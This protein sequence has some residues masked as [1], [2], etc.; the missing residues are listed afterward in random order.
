MSTTL[1]WGALPSDL[2]SHFGTS[3]AG[4]NIYFANKDAD[5][6]AVL[7]LTKGSLTSSPYI[8][9]DTDDVTSYGPEVTSVMPDVANGTYRFCVRNFTGESGG[10]LCDSSA[11]VRVEIPSQGGDSVNVAQTRSVPTTC[12]SG[13]YLLWQV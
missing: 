10:G 2:D 4:T 6:N 11:K 3:D 8:A 12:P 5:D 1:T 9:L 7:D 13:S